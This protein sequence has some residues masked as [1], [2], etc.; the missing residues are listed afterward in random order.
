MRFYRYQIVM[1]STFDLIISPLLLSFLLMHFWQLSKVHNRSSSV[2]YLC[3]LHCS[4]SPA[5]HS[6]WYIRILSL[7]FSSLGLCID[8]SLPLR[9]DIFSNDITLPRCLLYAP[10]CIYSAVFDENKVCVCVRYS[11]W[12]IANTDGFVFVFFCNSAKYSDSSHCLE[13]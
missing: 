11:T 9:A 12:L 4:F 1:I 2:A 6:P 13:K 7:A 8:L 10:N 3:S 5:V